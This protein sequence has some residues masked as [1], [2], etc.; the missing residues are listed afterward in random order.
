MPNE[1]GFHPDRLAR[2]D[3][4]LAEKYVTPAI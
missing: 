1:L 4:F 3:R 2:I